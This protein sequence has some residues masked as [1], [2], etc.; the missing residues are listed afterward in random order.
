MDFLGGEKRNTKNKLNKGKVIKT[1]I[2]ASVTLLIICLFLLYQNVSDVRNF[3]DVHIF[4][5]VVQEEK[6]PKIEVDTSKG[7]NA[8]AYNRYISI[9]DQNELKLYNKS[10]NQE[11]KLDVEI[12]NP[13]FDANG[14]YLCVA[15]KGGEKIY[16]ISNKNIVWQKEIEGNISGINVNKNG[17]VS[18]TITGTSYKTVVQTF[19]SKGND[20][21]KIYLSSTNVIATD[22]SNDNKYL[23]IAE[24]NFS[25]IIIQS[26][27][28]IIS[29]ND[30]KRNS[31]NS[32]KY[33]YLS[34]ANDLII[35]IKYNN[36]NNL[37]C[38]YDGHIDLLKGENSTELVDLKDRN[39]LFADVNLENKIVEITKNPENIKMPVQVKLVNSNNTKSVN[40]YE[41]NSSPKRIYVK[42]KIIAI[43]LGTSVLFIN[44]NGSLI[45]KYESRREDI[46][47]IIISNELAGIVCRD[48]INIISL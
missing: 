11:H 9:L 10:G 7:I 30:A 35:N 41:M 42:G 1:S 3:F 48:K 16:L 26:N 21:F 31:D 39:I 22:I 8:Y 5:K 2:I 27:I 46:Q 6:L 44:E 23:A 4:R 32:I 14:K 36:R 33:T 13:L 37:I 34:K 17:Y 40:I 12:S 38:M 45:K 20:L 28:K 25:G 24:A 18:V 43:N 29:I 19:D 47:N 15:E